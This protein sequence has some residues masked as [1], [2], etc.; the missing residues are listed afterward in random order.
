[1][2]PSLRSDELRAVQRE[3][4][5]VIVELR[6]ALLSCAFVE[7]ASPEQG[8]YLKPPFPSD[9]GSVGWRR[10]NG[11]VAYGPLTSRIGAT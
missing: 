1:M 9:G 10:H 4:A 7:F 3:S 6:K 11:T 5:Q 2:R 8:G